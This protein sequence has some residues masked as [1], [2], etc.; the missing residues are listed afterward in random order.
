M[1]RN[2]QMLFAEF[3]TMGKITAKDKAKNKKRIF[4]GGVRIGK[5]MYRTSDEVEKYKKD[6]LDRK[7]P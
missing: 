7:L 2:E 3:P 4:T 1:I 6:S 5:G